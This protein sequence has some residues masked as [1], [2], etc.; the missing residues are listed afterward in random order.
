MLSV[1]AR[2]AC[3]TAVVVACM[4]G[5]AVAVHASPTVS[6]GG[7]TGDRANTLVAIVVD[8]TIVSFRVDGGAT[9]PGHDQ[10]QIVLAGQSQQLGDGSFA[11]TSVPIGVGTA[12][13]SL[14]GHFT[15]TG[16]V[17]DHGIDGTIETTVKRTKHG[18]T[19]AC[20]VR[21]L[22]A[23]YT[24]R[25]AP[26]PAG[27]PSAGPLAQPLFGTT[28]EDMGNAFGSVAVFPWKPAGRIYMVWVVRGRCSRGFHADPFINL[29][30]PMRLGPQGAFA[31]HER[32][33]L[34][35]L[36]ANVHV[37]ADTTGTLLTD[38]A[39]GV[40]RLRQTVSSLH[41]RRLG[42]CDT[43]RVAWSAVP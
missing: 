40:V 3:C 11:A 12:G 29:T 8:D 39:Q 21:G 10:Q 33:T 42:R 38:G 7:T 6:G 37:R 2:S 31:R 18:H 17:T 36:D 23:P 41:G 26:A 28:K 35:L 34:R 15:I 27:A 9:C 30:P 19:A 32:F 24:T 4:L 43:G 13:E 5:G 20:Q 22:N 14:T 16:R 25:N 1:V